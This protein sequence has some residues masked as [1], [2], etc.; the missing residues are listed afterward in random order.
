MGMRRKYQIINRG[1]LDINDKKVQDVSDWKKIKTI[2]FVDHHL[3]FF[4]GEII[5]SNWIRISGISGYAGLQGVTGICK[6]E[7]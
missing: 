3:E 2:V 4:I 5:G 6:K 7:C 1:F